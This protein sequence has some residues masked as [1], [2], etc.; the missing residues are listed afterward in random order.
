MKYLLLL[1]LIPTTG[2]AKADLKTRIISE[3]IERSVIRLD[4][5][6]TRCSAI[7]YSMPELKVSAPDLKWL[8]IYN[9]ANEGEAEPC[10]TAGYCR[11]G[12]D[13]SKLIDPNNPTEEVELKV[14]V[15]ENFYL[16]HEEKKCSRV[17][18]EYVITKI[19]G[20]PFFHSRYSNESQMP[21]EKCVAI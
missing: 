19:R 9:H 20:I 10:I 3:K 15:E 16:F 7:G 11:N 4:A 5:S 2:L 21:Y 8:T 6:T 17:V 14:V 12:N 18:R 13:P 1:A